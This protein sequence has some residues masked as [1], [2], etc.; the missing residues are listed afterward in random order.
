MFAIHDFV[1]YAALPWRW[2]L[3]LRCFVAAPAQAQTDPLPSW[4]DTAP[5]A[6]IVAFVEKVTTEGSAGLRARTR[7]HRR[8]R[9]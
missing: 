6:A 5:K 8:V 9:Q 4:N 7:T 1:R 3:L 2:P